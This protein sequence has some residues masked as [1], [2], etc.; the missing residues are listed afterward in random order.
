[1][2]KKIKAVFFIRFLFIH[3][4]EGQKLKVSKYN[5]DLQKIIGIRL[6]HYKSF[7]NRFII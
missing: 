7:T 4:S 1:M 3:I 5:K 2:L 6:L